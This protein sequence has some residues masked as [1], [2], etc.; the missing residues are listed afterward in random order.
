MH[1]FETAFVAILLA[2]SLGDFVLQSER[3]IAAKTTIRGY[4]EHGLVHYALLAG[5][6][7][8]LS[9][10]IFSIHIEILLLGY[11]SIHLVIDFVKHTSI[12]RKLV[13]DS[14]T[15]FIADQ[16]LH[17]L[18]MALLARLLGNMTWHQLAT[19]F[20]W[21][22]QSRERVLATGVVYTLAIFAGGYLVRY[23]TNSLAVERPLRY[24]TNSLAVERPLNSTESEQELRNAGMY[25]GWLER[26]LVITAVMMQS[27]AL[28]GLILTGKSIA[29][30][31]ELKEARFAEY[32][33][34]GTS[35]SISIAL[36]G[37]LILARFVYGSISL[38]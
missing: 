35:L 7:C 38:K 17:F 18:T 33:L 34:I 2:H 31:P 11:V 28:I 20:T 16:L 23:L 19:Q 29:R 30:F 36:L 10:D 26:F 5:S 37:G 27:P 22:V 6:L 12:S 3:M 13:A 4:V 21:S 24:L 25:I 9:R 8:F 14:T 32:F 15:V 1:P